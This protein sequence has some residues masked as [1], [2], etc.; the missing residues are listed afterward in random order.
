MKNSMKILKIIIPILLGVYLLICT[1]LYFVQEKLLFQNSTLPKSHVFNFNIPLEEINIKTAD[2]IIL[3]SLLFKADSSKGVVLF[4]HGNGGTI[5]MWGRGANLYTQNN[6][7]ILYL[8][9]RGYGKS[10][11]TIS[12]EKQFVN[13]AQVAY[14][15]LK[16]RYPEENI[17]VSGTSMGT[18]LATQIA[19]KNNPKQLIL[20]APYSSMKTVIQEKVKIV[21]GFIVKYP[22][23]TKKH[24]K[25]VN[26]P[27]TIFHGTKDVVIP[28][29]HSLKLK[30][31][32]AKAVLHTLDGYG[33]Y[34]R[35]S[36]VYN[37][38]TMKLLE[39]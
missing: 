36:P 8:D 2:N 5:D 7:D 4:L 9:Y 38:E 14:D 15:Y 21:P 37:R 28:H 17:I 3:N 20:N 30:E 19:A 18:G 22:L 27:I 1:I 31:S 33:H 34:V 6:Y 11:G 35:N 32:N 25:E 29:H 16:G 13:D 39:R 26:C 24:I 23:N 12:S 10:G